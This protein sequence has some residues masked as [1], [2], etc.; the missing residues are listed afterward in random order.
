MLSKFDAFE[1]SNW[2]E[3]MVI[4]FRSGQTLIY[5]KSISLWGRRE[6]EECTLSERCLNLLFQPEVKYKYSSAS[7]RDRKAQFPHSVSKAHQ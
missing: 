5:F 4:L 1:R 6:G 2:K 7:Y 3:K